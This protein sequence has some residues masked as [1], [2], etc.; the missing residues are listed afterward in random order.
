[1]PGKYVDWYRPASLAELLALKQQFPAAKIV[2]G[3]TEVR[4]GPQAR[5]GLGVHSPTGRDQGREGKACSLLAEQ[6][7]RQTAACVDPC[8]CVQVGIEMKFK[9]A[10]YPVIIAPTHVPELNR[11][12]LSADGSAL[13]VRLAGS[14]GGRGDGGS[15]CCADQ[16][17]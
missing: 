3:N 6:F 2:V 11:I 10:K 13:E 5:T 14:G 9:D 7:C 8:V 16:Q 1:M 12:G 4:A 15:G 17:D